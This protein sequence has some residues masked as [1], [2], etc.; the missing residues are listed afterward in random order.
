MFIRW[1]FRILWNVL[2]NIDFLE[3][4]EFKAKYCTIS[5][6]ELNSWAARASISRMIAHF[7]FVHSNSK[8]SRAYDASAHLEN[9]TAFGRH[10]SHIQ[11]PIESKRKYHL[12][13]LN[14]LIPYLTFKIIID[15]YTIHIP[16]EENE[17]TSFMIYISLFVLIR[18]YA[19]WRVSVDSFIHRILKW[20]VSN[21]WS[22]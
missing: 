12:W 11:F 6:N 17:F 15:K 21:Q 2:A 22:K 4:S 16:V 19:E 1:K 10:T 14:F 18:D 20:F 7:V 9:L 3:R 8:I 13:L 5:M